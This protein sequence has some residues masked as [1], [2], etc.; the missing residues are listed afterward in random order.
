MDR[1]VHTMCVCGEL[2]SNRRIM[3]VTDSGNNEEG[4]LGTMKHI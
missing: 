2:R 4:S 3:C 1:A